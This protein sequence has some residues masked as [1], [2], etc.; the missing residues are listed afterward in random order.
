MSFRWEI[1]DSCDHPNSLM[2]IYWLWCVISKA[3][4]S[5]GWISFI[6]L[7]ICNVSRNFGPILFN[8]VNDKFR[9]GNHFMTRNHQA[10][11]KYK[12]YVCKYLGDYQNQVY[13][14]LFNSI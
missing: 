6:I 12:F 2:V 11:S 7:L 4:I 8:N 9:L 10:F 14:I 13:G 5:S 1:I 3:I